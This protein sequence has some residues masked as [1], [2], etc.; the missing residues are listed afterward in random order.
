MVGIKNEPKRCYENLPVG[1][2]NLDDSIKPTIDELFD[3]L[4]H[5]E[6]TDELRNLV[7]KT[8]QSGVDYGDA[9]ARL[10][11]DFLGKYGLIVL[12]PLDARLKKLATPV[13]VE[14]IRKSD[15][16]VSALRKR[17]EELESDGYHAQVLVTEDYFPLFWQSK[18]RTSHALKKSA[19]GT[20]KTKDIER[21]FTLEE[22]AE[23][24]SVEPQKFSPSVVL[25]SVVQDYLLPTDLLF[26]RRG[27]N[28]LFCAVGGSL[29]NFGKS[30]YADFSSSK[31]Y[32]CRIKTRQNAQKI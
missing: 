21:E 3:E 4:P 23:L 22:L 7:E 8:W 5:T 31:F 25:R 26:R 19:S 32:D 13:Y 2:V 15:E 20:F 30:D 14:A 10:L 24:A 16:I 28:C 27:R 9:F 17:S 11:T 1:Y 6:F 29:S 12:C 18:D